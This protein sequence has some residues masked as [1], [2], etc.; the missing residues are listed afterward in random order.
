MY[1]GIGEPAAAPPPPPP[2]Q[3]REPVPFACNI[4]V[5]HV[6]LAALYC[7]ALLGQKNN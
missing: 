7:D 6:M 2:L 4:Y 1:T 3:H 5:H